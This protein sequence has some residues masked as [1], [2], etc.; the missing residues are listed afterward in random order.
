MA[1]TSGKRTYAQNVAY[2]IR[3]SFIPLF[4]TYLLSSYFVPGTVL[5]IGR[6]SDEQSRQDSCPRGADILVGMGVP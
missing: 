1:P 5:G 3:A 2:K 4:H 6:Y